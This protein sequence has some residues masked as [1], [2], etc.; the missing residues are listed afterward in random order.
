MQKYIANYLKV[1]VSSWVRIIYGFGINVLLFLPLATGVCYPKKA[2]GTFTV[3]WIIGKSLRWQTRRGIFQSMGSSRMRETPIIL[4]QAGM[5]T[6]HKICEN[7]DHSRARDHR[8]G[9]GT[10]GSEHQSRIIT[11]WL[12]G[13]NLI[14]V[15]GCHLRKNHTPP[16]CTWAVQT[17]CRH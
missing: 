6:V 7:R 12:S 9:H 15:T 8:G 4:D 16:L 13:F 14:R 17:N 5:F 3:S 11:V 1:L 10:C 2:R